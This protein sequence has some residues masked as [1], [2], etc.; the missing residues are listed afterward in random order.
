MSTVKLL[1]VRVREVDN[2]HV[3]GIDQHLI[4]YI[5]RALRQRKEGCLADEVLEPIVAILVEYV[6][7]VERV[8]R[9]EETSGK[10]FVAELRRQMHALHHVSLFCLMA[11]NATRGLIA[12]NKCQLTSCLVKQ[13][14]LYHSVRAAGIGDSAVERE[15]PEGNHYRE[16]DRVGPVEWIFLDEQG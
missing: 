2:I 8:R 10:R 3:H 9:G 6:F 15:E 1:N 4:I 14:R 5:H 16:H 11:K 7:V 12:V 13:N